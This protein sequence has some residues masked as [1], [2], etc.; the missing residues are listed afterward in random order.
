MFFSNNI[1]FEMISFQYKCSIILEKWQLIITNY[2]TLFAGIAVVP[3]Y[4]I[5]TYK[6][7]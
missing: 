6:F 3:G 1:F 4:K 2:L 5:S 7:A